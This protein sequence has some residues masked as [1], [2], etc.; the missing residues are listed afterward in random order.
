MSRSDTAQPITM[1]RRGILSAA[2]ALPVMA[3]AQWPAR[4]FAAEFDVDAF[5]RLSQDL[6]A[7][8]SLAEGIGAELLKGFAATDRRA[9]LAGLAEG[10]EAGDLANAVV[11]SWYSGVSPDPGETEV[12][13]YTEALMW[14]AMDFTKPQGVCGGVM[15]YWNGAPGA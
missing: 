14:D 10:A 1:T 2:S 11:A 8:D 12:A 5:L 7:R 3:L 9:D 4:A 6:T 15:G 13:T